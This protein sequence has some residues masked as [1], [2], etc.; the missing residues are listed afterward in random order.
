MIQENSFFLPFK[1]FVENQ[2]FF[3]RRHVSNFDLVISTIGVVEIFGT[4][5]T[6]LGTFFGEAFDD[7]HV[8]I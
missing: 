6:L 7:F 8:D 5:L 3:P 4:G 1:L 2:F